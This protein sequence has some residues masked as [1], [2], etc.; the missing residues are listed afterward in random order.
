MK[1]LLFILF[2]LPIVVSCSQNK[3]TKEVE[4][5]RNKLEINQHKTDAF[6]LFP[7]QN[8]WTFIKLD[9][10]NGKM[11]QVQ[12]DVR[13]DNRMETVLNDKSL[14]SNGGEIYGRFNLYATQNIFNFILLDKV[15]GGTWQV[16]WSIEEDKRG[17]FP[18]SE[19]SNL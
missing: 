12:Y 15:S 19:A 5:T 2:A 6:E 16:Q 14:V 9:T 1:K 18:I 8:M 4:S 13:G 17:I 10:R 3:A 7:T 11:W